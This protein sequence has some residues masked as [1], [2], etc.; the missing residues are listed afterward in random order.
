MQ[1]WDSEEAN[2][3]FAWSKSMDLNGFLIY[4]NALNIWLPRNLHSLA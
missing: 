2:M 1:E 4:S 3:C